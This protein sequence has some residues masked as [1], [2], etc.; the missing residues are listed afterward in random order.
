MSQ[1][2]FFHIPSGTVRFWVSVDG[3]LI[4]ASIGKEALHY[5][6]KPNASD[7]DPS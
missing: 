7:D 5:R 3:Q 1:E 4:G 6:Y 2:P